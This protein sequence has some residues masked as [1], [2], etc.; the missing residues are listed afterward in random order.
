LLSILHC[1]LSIDFDSPYGAFAYAYDQALGRRFFDSVSRLLEEIL[2]RQEIEGRSHLDVACGTGLAVPFFQSRG[3]RSVGADLSLPMLQRARLRTSALVAADFRRLPFRGPFSLVTC[4]YDSLNHLMTPEALTESFRSIRRVMSGSSLFV[5]D[6]NHP[7]VYPAIW[8][9]KQ[10]FVASG[11][12]YLLKMATTFSRRDRIGK[13]VVTGWARLGSGERV[14]IEETHRQRSYDERAI[15]GALLAAGLR[16]V[17]MLDFDPYDEV[18]IST[19]AAGVK[20]V[21]VCRSMDNG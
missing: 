7:D 11:P 13:A 16:I 20:L 5:F 15:R 21:F 14:M 8:G 19:T 1:P 17:E 9:L 2:E 3:F 18:G 6:M 10:P 4:L 12:D